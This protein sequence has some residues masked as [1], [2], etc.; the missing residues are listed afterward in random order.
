MAEPVDADSKGKPSSMTISPSG[1]SGELSC[2]PSKSMTHRAIIAASLASGTSRVSNYL[3]SDDTFA[4]INCM[5][6]LGAEIIHEENSLLITGSVP[7]P[8]KQL[9][10]HESGTTIRMLVPIMAVS[11]KGVISASGSLLN[12]PMHDIVDSFRDSEVGIRSSNGNPPIEITSKLS[13][14]YH[15]ISGRLTSQFISGLLF[16]LP[17]LEGDSVLSIT[18]AA[19]SKPYISMSLQVLEDFGVHVREQKDF[20]EF[21]VKGKQSFK[22]RD[23]SVEGDWSNAAFFIAWAVIAGSL[24]I[25]ELRKDSLQADLAILKFIRKMGSGAMSRNSCLNVNKCRLKGNE[26]SME[27]CPDLLPIM[28][29]LACF[30][31]GRTVLTDIERIRFKESDRVS[32][33][34]EELRKMG[35]RIELT[36]KGLQIFHSDLSCATVDSHNDHRIAMALAIA[37]KCS[38]GVVI[39][40]P[41]CVSKSFPDFFIVLESVSVNES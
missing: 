18:G 7:L 16:A 1:C 40:N 28:C 14:G 24:R 5:R 26:F 15:S 21:L 36:E 39:T 6:A 9:Y 27:H 22:P 19:S 32:A 8:N 4:T 23:Y 37:G 34:V 30:A 12:R 10:A 35:A 20:T 11:G 41:G 33:M 29:V 25:K 17:L 31:R 38:K 3:K 2:P 13:P